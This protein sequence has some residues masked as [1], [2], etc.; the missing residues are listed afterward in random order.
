MLIDLTSRAK[1][2]LVGE[3]CLRFL[4][5]QLTNDLR[6][7]QTGETVYACAL[8]AKGKLCGDLYVTAADDGFLLDWET[9]LRQG[10]AA[11]LERYII[12]DDVALED[13]TEQFGLL[14]L[15]DQ[16][17]P[18]Q[19]PKEVM[20]ARS[21]RFAEL[22]HDLFFPMQ[23]MAELMSH[24][25]AEPLTAGQLEELRIERGI[26]KW[27]S[28]LAEDVIPVEA[29][30]DD[31]AIS[32][33]KG[34]YLGQEIISRIKS[35][36]HV[37]R[38]LR[39]LRLLQGEHIPQGAQMALSDGKIVGKVTSSCLSERI[40]AW[41]GLGFVRRGSDTPGTCLELRHNSDL[42]GTVEVRSLPLTQCRFADDK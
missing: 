8:T 6:Q 1:F 16:A 2:R 39:G 38:H 27:G 37:N 23:L 25:G 40:G 33:T 41:I 24:L 9:A 34:C 42:I 12:A 36:G 19:M 7:L 3:D 30:L 5:G 15:L 31:R 22:G 4:N 14:H 11:R 32:Y 10:L 17:L 21:N 28:E 13:V 18:E 35:V 20:A 29:G 26:P